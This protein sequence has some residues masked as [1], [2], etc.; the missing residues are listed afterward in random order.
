M[1]KVLGNAALNLQTSFKIPTVPSLS[2]S[3]SNGG[4][5]HYHVTI[6][7]LKVTGDQNG[8]KTLLNTFVNGVR[9]LGGNI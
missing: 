9:K 6:G 2:P 5:N 4:D 8:A 7:D 3:I 1:G